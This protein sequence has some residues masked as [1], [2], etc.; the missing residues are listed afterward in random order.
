[1]IFNKES[2]FEN[3]LITLL[4]QKG[5]EPEVLRYKTEKEL[6]QN[7]AN[8]LFEN[9]RGIDRLNDYPLTEGEMQQILE[10]VSQL[11][12]PLKLNGF[13]NGKT[14]TIRRDNPDDKLHYGSEVSLK[15]YDRQE[16][17]AGQSRYQIAQQPKF[18]AKTSI[19]PD[20][21]GDFILLINGMPLIHVELKKSGVDVMQACNQIE[22]YTHEGVFTGFFSLVQVFVAMTPEETLYFANPGRDGKFNRDYYFHWANF[23]NQPINNWEAIASH[24]LSIPMAH[25]LI[26]FYTV[27]D[28][29]DGV[30]KVMRSYQYYAA[31]A[32]SDRVAKTKWDDREIY[33]GYVWHTTGSGKTLTS[34]KSAQ[35]I[36]NSRDADKVVFLM[37]RIELG[38]QS[39]LEYRGFADDSEDVQA[40]EN[41]YVLLSKLKSNDP[42]NTLIVTSIQKM[43]RIEEDGVFNDRDI[44]IIGQ[45]RLVFIIDECH[46]STFGEMLSTI[47]ETFPH[48]LFF[49]FTG[50][51]IHDENQ[52]KLSTT[53]S[54]F[55]N[56]LHRYS[57]ADGIRDKNVLG[58][59]PYMVQTFLEREIRHVVAL[60]QAKAQSEAD[61]MADPAKRAVYLRFVEPT[62][63]PMVGHKDDGGFY[64]KG[65]EDYLPKA[66]YTSPEHQNAVV[67]DI[68]DNFFRLSR[69]GQFHAIFATS[70]IAEAMTYYRLFKAKA[71]HL[72]VAGLFDPSIDNNEGGIFKEEGLIELLEDYNARY[73]QTF[74]LPSFGRYKKDIAL[75][76]AH[77]EQYRGISN[78]PEEQID[79]LIVVDQMLTGY[80]SKWVN[81]LYLDKLLRYEGLIQAFSRTNRIF[82]IHEK[83]FGNIRYYRK[84]FTMCSNIEA[85]FRLYSGDKPL[86]LF[87]DKLEKNLEEMNE[88]FDQITH[89]FAAAGISDFARLPDETTERA[90]FASLFK[91]LSKHYEAARIQGFSWSKLV[92][93]F[94][95]DEGDRTIEV[96]CDENTYLVLAVRYKELSISKGP[97]T[98]DVPFEI[99]G[100]LTEISTGSIDAEYMNTRF[101]KYLKSLEVGAQ[102][103]VDKALAELHKTFSS[104]S[105]EDQKYALLFLHD[106]QTGS[107]KIQ[108]GKTLL[109]YITEYHAR[110]KDDQIHRF[111]LAVGVNEELLRDY[112]KT[113]VSGTEISNEFGRFDKL[114]E[115]VDMSI[116]QSFVEKTEGRKLPAFKVRMRINEILRKFILA[117]GFDI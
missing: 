85:A 10:Q 79:I 43:S 28:S 45:K 86:G 67:E 91:K 102:E 49:G 37:D 13:I 23:N 62:L 105:Q 46:R 39:L 22:K 4:F 30:L 5:W 2:E 77:K 17:A 7:W 92:Y 47:K 6:I 58:F 68:K 71:P 113:H 51:P 95:K 18:T 78:K 11:R 12:T 24:L 31:S 90:K 3:A 72:K 111:A 97:Q 32:I 108:S 96:K 44:E 81:T 34:F 89:L 19:L 9:N 20:R 55:G 107:V 38:T 88:A 94:K 1:M 73:N 115:S 42:S 27:A 70:S 29:G 101:E 83:P 36:A 100:Y 103:E 8:I 87:A 25:Q 14:V 26:G 33:G 98:P 93:V 99:D 64:H 63:T 116:A 117:D 21:R 106:I 56:E 76:L 109:D 52:K 53:A 80:D 74:T 114:L 60:Q 48:A 15:I 110:A 35:L 16:I 54:V 41:T 59:Y 65:I 84:P 40:T 61:V 57:I 104:L 69:G 66:Q 50:T 82:D 112:M 75:R